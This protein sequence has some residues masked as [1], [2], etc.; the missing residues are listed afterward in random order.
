MSLTIFTPLTVARH[1]VLPSGMPCR[2]LIYLSKVGDRPLQTAEIS[3][4]IRKPRLPCSGDMSLRLRRSDG[5]R[6][7][8]HNL[9]SKRARRKLDKPKRRQNCQLSECCG[10]NDTMQP[11]M[12]Q[13][14]SKERAVARQSDIYEN[15][16]TTLSLLRLGR[17]RCENS[18]QFPLQAVNFEKQRRDCVSVTFSRQKEICRNT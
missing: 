16:P 10:Q 4:S 13:D 5:G 8:G 9:P 18:F 2:P 14:Q 12:E 11:L 7:F 3:R 6:T 17:D 1:E 15:A